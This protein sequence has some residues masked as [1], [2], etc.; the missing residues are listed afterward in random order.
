[1]VENPSLDSSLMQEEIFGPV[2][3]ILTIESVDEAIKCTRY[4]YSNFFLKVVNA[5][6][7]P[8]ALYVFSTNT[9]NCEKVM[10]KTYFGGGAVN[11]CLFQYLCP[12]LPFGGGKFS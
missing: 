10:S 4:L 1:M 6:A 3:P 7:K 9:A 12:E 8:L 2:L 11:E 5:R